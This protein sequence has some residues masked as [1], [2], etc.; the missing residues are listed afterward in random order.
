MAQESPGKWG[1][2][3][4][5]S[6][7]LNQ[8]L[9]YFETNPLDPNGF[10]YRVDNS[11][12]VESLWERTKEV[13]HHHKFVHEHEDNVDKKLMEMKSNSPKGVFYSIC[14][15]GNE[16]YYAKFSLRFIV[17]NKP[18]FHTI[19]IAPAGFVW[20]T[21]TYCRLEHLLANFEYPVIYFR[22]PTTILTGKLLLRV[23]L[24]TDNRLKFTQ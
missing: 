8:L 15:F 14:W 23:L 3:L 17:G 16:D 9:D 11:I 2:K 6:P 5:I 18:K 13:M 10:I 1:R 24:K 19:V 12:K 4:R 20:G 22:F 21:T 7:D